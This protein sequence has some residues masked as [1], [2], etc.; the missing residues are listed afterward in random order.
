MKCLIYPIAS[1]S[2]VAALSSGLAAAAL[3]VAVPIT[4]ASAYLGW[5]G[6]ETRGRSLED[7][8]ASEIGTVPEPVPV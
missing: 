3:V 8:A 4:L 6:V 1:R 7:I 5:K 2:F